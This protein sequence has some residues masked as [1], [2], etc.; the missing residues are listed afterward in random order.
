MINKVLKQ[1]LTTLRVE[2][3][4]YPKLLLVLIICLCALVRLWKIEYVPFANDADELAHIYAGQS[5]FELRTPISWSSFSHQIWRVQYIDSPSINEQPMTALVKPWLDHPPFL[6]VMVGGLSLLFGYHFPSIPPAL[7][8]RLPM[9]L[10]SVGT[11]LLFFAISKKIFGFLP[12]LVGLVFIGFSPTFFF[13]Q[14]MVVGENLLLFFLLL[15]LYFYLHKRSLFIVSLTCL[16]AVITKLTGLI[17]PI[18]ITG[19]ML[20]QRKWSRA[21][22]FFSL[23]LLLCLGSSLLLGVMIGG[24]GYFDA[25]RNQSY[26]LVGWLN[27]AFIFSSPGFHT[28]VILD[29]SYIA[30]IIS[31]FYLFVGPFKSNQRLIALSV[32]AQLVLVWATAA[33]QDMLGW[34]K[35]PL[36]GL[37]SFGVA[38]LMS[39]KQYL[40]LQILVCLTLLNN[41]GMVRFPEH[42][43]P[44]SETLRLWLVGLAAGFLYL[45]GKN[46]GQ[47]KNVLILAVLLSLYV[48]QGFWIADNYFAA[49]CKDRVCSTPTVTFRSL[50][51]NLISK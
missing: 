24:Q 40:L 36:F 37:L 39:H 34:Y 5:F 22:A 4:S 38:R 42:P 33:E 2:K 44:S 49:I 50:V 26:R 19:D 6:G 47:R 32:V 35:I 7:L 16:L 10:I 17:I 45:I 14:R 46:I 18:I 43:L 11:L 8:Y 27:P 41:M 23:T 20:L 21:I 13:I 30:I 51:K 1:I 3:K 15:S 25:L 48:A 31:G 28:K 12:A 9:V 29:F